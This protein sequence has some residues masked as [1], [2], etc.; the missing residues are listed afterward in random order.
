MKK[1]LLEEIVRKTAELEFKNANEKRQKEARLNNETITNGVITIVGTLGN[2]TEIFQMDLLDVNYILKP[3]KDISDFL[4]CTFVAPI[5]NTT[6]FELY[7]LFQKELNRDNCTNSNCEKHSC[8]VH[9][10]ISNLLDDD[11]IEFVT[12][13]ACMK[14]HFEVENIVTVRKVCKLEYVVDEDI[15]FAYLLR[16]GS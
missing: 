7:S 5:Q 1:A 10:E 15:M 8:N 2:V 12:Y 6:L 11:N 13:V 14:H 3:K 9:E 16:K 4:S